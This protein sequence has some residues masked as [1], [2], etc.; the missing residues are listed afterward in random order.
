MYWELPVCE[1][2]C[3][4]L[5]FKDEL[6]PPTPPPPKKKM[7]KAWVIL[8]DH[9]SYRPIMDY[10]KTLYR[11]NSKNIYGIADKIPKPGVFVGLEK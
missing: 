4:V 5:E 11:C 2:Q 7:N 10:L 6:D 1:A 8:K 9:C 3:K